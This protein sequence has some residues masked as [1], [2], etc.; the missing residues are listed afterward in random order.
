MSVKLEYHQCRVSSVPPRWNDVLS[1]DVSTWN[2]EF[3]QL[4]LAR[5]P[6]SRIYPVQLC[7]YYWV[8]CAHYMTSGSANSRRRMKVKCC[9]V[10]QSG[11]ENAAVAGNDDPA[12]RHPSRLN[13]VAV[14]GGHGL[15]STPGVSRLT[16]G[17]NAPAGHDYAVRA[18]ADGPVD[19]HVNSRL[20][21]EHPAVSCTSDQLYR[22]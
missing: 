20:T 1:S 14:T 7:S 12:S 21:A 11:Q 16:P 2:S 13:S 15:Q 18:H 9:C 5:L 19:M 10:W 17:D 6:F 8:L 22:S 4:I 3:Q